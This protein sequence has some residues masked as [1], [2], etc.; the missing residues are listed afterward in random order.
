MDEI[1]KLN[2][3][4]AKYGGNRDVIF[5]ALALDPAASLTEF[6]KKEQFNYLHVGSARETM[7]LFGNKSYSREMSWLAG[8]VR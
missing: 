1:P 2:E 8:M 4:A 5:I 6:L 3:L 7:D